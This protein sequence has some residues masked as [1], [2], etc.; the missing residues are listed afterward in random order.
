MLEPK[1]I[2]FMRKNIY[3]RLEVISVL[4]F[5]VGEKFVSIF[6]H[7]GIRQFLGIIN[8]TFGFIKIQFLNLTHCYS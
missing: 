6:A 4:N 3:M 8:N 7:Y 1:D 5:V 2:N